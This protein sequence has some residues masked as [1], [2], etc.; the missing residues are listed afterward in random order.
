MSFFW[1][2]YHPTLQLHITLHVIPTQ[3]TSSPF[4]STPTFLL[5]HISPPTY[6]QTPHPLRDTASLPWR[7]SHGHSTVAGGAIHSAPH[8]NHYSVVHPQNAS[9]SRCWT[10][11]TAVTLKSQYCTFLSLCANS[12][13]VKKR[14]QI[15][16]MYHKELLELCVVGVLHFLIVRLL[17]CLVKNWDM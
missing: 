15:F 4:S 10:F 13:K 3:T 17:M 5:H 1:I 7:H 12:Y 16:V 11:R 2:T 14:D 9:K 8:W 6:F